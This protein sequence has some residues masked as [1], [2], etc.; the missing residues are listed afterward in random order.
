MKPITLQSL[1]RPNALACVGSGSYRFCGSEQCAVV[2]FAEAGDSVFT[3]DDL[4]VRVGIKETTSPRQVCY[5]FNHTIEE[6][7]D[8][9]GCTG[10]TTVLDNIKTCMKEACWCETKNPLGSCCLATVTKYVKEILDRH[11]KNA[12][13]VALA[14][15]PDDC[16]AAPGHAPQAST[17]SK[18]PHPPRGVP[19]AEKV[20]WIGSVLSAVVACACC[21]LPLLLL[22]V[23]VSGVAVSANFGKYRPIFMAVTFAFLA[24]AF[25]FA[26]RPRTKPV[27]L[28]SAAGDACCAAPASGVDCC[29]P[30]GR[31]WTLQ[32]LNRV[33]LWVVA[34]ITLGFLFFPNYV[35]TLLGG[36][37]KAEFPATLDQV[38]LTL[39][40]MDCAACAAGLE[41][42]LRAV[43]GVAAAMVS[44][45]KKEAVI[46]VPKGSV[47]QEAIERVVENA[48]YRVSGQA[49]W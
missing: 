12:E 45:E 27:A 47:K 25:Y 19:T 46:G 16:C 37:N 44:Y 17:G 8:E 14:E 38:V 1:L 33:M 31:K 48:G 18:G 40:G 29:P 39:D 32:K 13:Q 21:W 15:Q 28:N 9:V 2:Y 22:T 26:Y 42:E 5:C 43:P 49:T 4:A 3:K 20:A 7:E 11:G 30:T 6:I 36:G 35:G 41:K 10:K 24:A 23:G 34:A